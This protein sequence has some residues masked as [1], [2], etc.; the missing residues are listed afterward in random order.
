MNKNTMNMKFFNMSQINP[1][2]NDDNI[3]IYNFL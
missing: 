2:N 3:I 1:C